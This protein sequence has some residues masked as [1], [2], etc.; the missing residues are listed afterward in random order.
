MATITGVIFSTSSGY[1]AVGLTMSYT[2]CCDF[3]TWLTPTY[4]F[5]TW[6]NPTYNFT[7]W[8]TLNDDFTTWL[9]PTDEFTTWLTPTDDFT[10][11]LTPTDDFTTWLTLT[12]VISLHD[13]QYSN[14]CEV[15]GLL[16]KYWYGFTIHWFTSIGVWRSKCIP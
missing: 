9:T 14:W 10:T 7:T 13:L 2:D 6:L 4:N 11:W 5:T 15:I 12:D 3:T 8:L 1:P 16:L